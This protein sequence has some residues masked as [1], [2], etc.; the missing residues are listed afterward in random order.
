M[1]EENGRNRKT[2][3]SD[4][5]QYI[6]LNS[7]LVS[8]SFKGQTIVAANPY[9][10]QVISISHGTRQLQK[11]LNTSSAAV[12]SWAPPRFSKRAPLSSA[13]VVTLDSPARLA[14]LPRTSTSGGISSSWASKTFVA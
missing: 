7:N 2:G 14:S 10:S 13:A 8:W 1:N 9:H 5:G 4:E 3:K 6:K 11:I 12:P